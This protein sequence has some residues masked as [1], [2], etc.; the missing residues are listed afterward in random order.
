M[1]KM[2]VSGYLKECFRG[3]KAEIMTFFKCWE[4]QERLYFSFNSQEVFPYPK[5]KEYNQPLYLG[6]TVEVFLTLDRP[7]KYLE[8]EANQ[9]GAQYCVIIDNKDGKGDII[10]NKLDKSIFQSQNLFEDNFWRCHIEIEKKQLYKIGW[11]E[12]AAF[13]NAH[14]QDFDKEGRLNIYSLFPT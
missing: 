12:D 5:F 11:R 7:N 1:N 9:L 13:I 2:L 10:I 3:Q 8:I 6:D 4:D 14:R